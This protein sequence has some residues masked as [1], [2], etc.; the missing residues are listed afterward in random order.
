MSIKIYGLK[1]S[2]FAAT[3]IG[4]VLSPKD[5]KGSVT[6]DVTLDHQKSYFYQ[7]VDLEDIQV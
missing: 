3:P 2:W 4:S 1:G 6:V 7:R 5:I